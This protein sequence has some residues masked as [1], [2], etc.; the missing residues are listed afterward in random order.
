VSGQL[1]LGAGLPGRGVVVTGAASGIGRATARL[2]S[3]VGANVVAVDR[4]GPGLESLVAESPG[5]GTIHPLVA[6]LADAAGYERIVETADGSLGGLY[7]LV[8]AAA[9]VKRQ[10]IAEV[11]DEDWDLQLDINLKSMFFLCRAAASIMA[12]RGE[13]GRIVNFSSAAWLTGPLYQSDAYVISKGGVV[14]LTRGFARQYGRFGILVNTIMPGQIDTPM[15][16]VD[17]TPAVV[18]AGIDACPLGRM[19]RP[20]ELASVALFLASDHA[21]F[22]T[23][24]TLNVSGG[25]VM[26]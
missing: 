2:F 18:Q 14:V 8:N 10:P 3:E 6:D 4:D 11:T 19:G 24:A 16:H 21:S 17:N 13:G 20:E 5:P 23:G 9:R 22:V 1:A 15:Q 26:Y 7:G 25:S 12:A